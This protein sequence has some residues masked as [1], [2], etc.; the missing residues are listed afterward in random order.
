MTLNNNFINIFG[1]KFISRTEIPKYCK[2]LAQQDPN[3]TFRDRQS[4][5]YGFIEKNCRGETF[6][7]V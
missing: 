1:E 2:N 3:D 4:E 6:V 7:K 5:L